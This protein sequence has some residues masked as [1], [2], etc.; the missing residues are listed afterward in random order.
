MKLMT[1]LYPIENESIRSF[2]LR[3]SIA[4][5]Y[6]LT[7]RLFSELNDST[8]VGMGSTEER[9]VSFVCSLVDTCDHSSFSPVQKSPR[10]CG[11]RLGYQAIT[12]RTPHVCAECMITQNH[13]DSHWQLTPITHCHKHQKRLISNCPCCE[14][15]LHWNEDLLHF[16]CSQ[17]DA[18]WHEIAAMLPE[19]QLPNYIEHF[20]AQPDDERADYLEDLLTAAMRALRPYD[21]VHHAI[22]QLPQLELD[23]TKLFT[24]A[25]DLLTNK[26]LIELWCQ[27]MIN[28]RR[29]YAEIGSGAV[30]Y[31]LKTM[32]TRLHQK[33]LVHAFAPTLTNTAISSDLMCFH[34]HTPCT[35]RNAAIAVLS[36][37][38]SNQQL[39]HH[40]DQHAFAQMLG[41]D[42]ALARK[43]FKVSSISS[44]TPV[45][46]G[47]YSFIDI[48]DFIEQTK[49][50]NT[51]CA[52][53][54]MKLNELSE[55]LD[56]YTID[57][58]DILVEIYKHNL[59]IY[60]D[61][62]ANTLVDAIKINEQLI[63]EHFETTYLEGEASI[64]LTRATHILRISRNR[65]KQLGALKL[66]KELPSK[67]FT[68]NYS[69]TSIAEFLSR[70][71]CI[72]RWA[73][74]NNVCADKI[75]KT[76]RGSNIQPVIA[77]FIYAR[78]PKL[79]Q[80]L[81]DHVNASWQQQEQLE[82]FPLA[83]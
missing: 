32:L 23:W 3:L 12:Q 75:I 41:C 36:D 59:P 4:N 40:I 78:T 33:W 30:F 34:H 55:L 47:R 83:G 77:P 2:L 56:I 79:E 6:E 29:K 49:R 21:S 44:V 72:E 42:L 81:N 35:T 25:Y 26:H 18:A 66:I 15:V 80:I 9:L 45:G 5:D 76:L 54:T 8:A 65:V 16:G 37:D 53:N 67:P 64:S 10:E 14:K 7:N 73:S 70:Y 24:Q 39:I 60:I 1:A 69:G 46:R 62:A 52:A 13:T 61:R 50:Q 28:Q 11:K 57:T 17:C 58:G 71:E 63:S 82:L 68:H 51:A 74:H 43:L 22:K 27:S 20:H 31:P 38:E 19:E 48:R